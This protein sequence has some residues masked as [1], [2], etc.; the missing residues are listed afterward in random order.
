MNET[1][2]LYFNK[3]YD[4]QT[5]TYY[6]S[7][8][9]SIKSIAELKNISLRTQLYNI[10]N[11]DDKGAYVIGLRICFKYKGELYFIIHNHQT[12][13]FIK[14]IVERLKYENATDIFIKYGEID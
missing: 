5:E 7:L 12:N 13:D 11:T 1:R 2:D 4:S 8:K 9:D 6:L 3:K 10:I 14:R